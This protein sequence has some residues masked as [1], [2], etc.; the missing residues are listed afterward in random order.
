MKNKKIYDEATKLINLRE[1]KSSNLDKA[2][3]TLKKLIDKDPECDWAFGLLSQIYYWRGETA[4]SEDR[5]DIYKQGMEYG[6]RGVEI[7]PDSLESNFWLAVNYGLFGN[8]RGVLESLRLI[9]PIEKHTRKAL[10]IDEGY[11]YGGPWRV[12][13]RLYNQLPGWPISRGDNKKALEFLNNALEYGPKFY[14][15]HLYI[16]DIYLALKDK[17]KAREHLQWVIKAPLSSHHEREDGRYKEE[18]KALLKKI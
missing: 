15:N 12:L 2:E 10:D 1:E 16:A 17:A 9:D 13:G 3:A 4:E 14:L 5:I 6:K 11:F 8:E 7:E 18:A